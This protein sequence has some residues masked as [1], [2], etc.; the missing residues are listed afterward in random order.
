MPTPT[1][2]RVTPAEAGT[3]LV[4]WLA[5]R[6]A[7]SRKQA[8]R[9]LDGR[10]VFVNRRRVWMAQHRLA[11]G[12]TVEVTGIRPPG[13]DARAPNLAILHDSHDVLVINKPA[14]ITTNGP[15]GAEEL[16]RRAHGSAWAVHRLDRDTTGCNLFARSPET[17]DRLVALFG[18]RAVAK[19][20]RVLAVGTVEPRARSIDTPI[21]GLSAH[22]ELRVIRSNRVASYLEARIE[23]GRTHQIRKHLR[24][25][26]HPVAGD[27]VYLT[28]RLD[29]PHL[30]ALPR[31]ML[32]AHSL[33]WSDPLTGAVVDVQAPLPPDFAGALH[34]LGLAGPARA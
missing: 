18:E 2:W 29:H 3:P 11:A 33:R 4:E 25:I 12:D 20:Y 30:R 1:P 24:D 13:R 31:Q 14:G 34:R 9:T 8:K 5:R 22:T 16:L 15:G 26:G 27:R 23:T 19:T 7:T 32:H 6:M 17:R 10:S 28:E 21:D